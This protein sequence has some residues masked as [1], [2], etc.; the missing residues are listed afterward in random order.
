ML[1]NLKLYS[2][3][4]EMLYGT[5]YTAFYFLCFNGWEGFLE[6]TQK[7]NNIRVF[8]SI[9]QFMVIIYIASLGTFR[10][11]VLYLYLQKHFQFI[12]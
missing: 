5:K 3:R 6:T 1:H 10:I 11:N 2:H 7:E 9:S 8:F 4:L 12:K